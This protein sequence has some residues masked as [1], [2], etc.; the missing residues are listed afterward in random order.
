MILTFSALIELHVNYEIPLR[1]A[2]CSERRGLLLFHVC[3][4]KE[5][6]LYYNLNCVMH[7]I[8][9][10]DQI[11]LTKVTEDV[12]CFSFSPLLFHLCYC[13]L[14]VCTK[15]PVNDNSAVLRS[16][17]HHIQWAVGQKI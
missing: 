16:Y 15:A 11:L 9:S 7:K 12:L 4:V 10:M 6:F 1:N 2:K 3:V 14:L 17:M 8:T 13:D 5:F